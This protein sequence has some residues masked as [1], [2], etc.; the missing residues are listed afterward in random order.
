MEENKMSKGKPGRSSS[1]KATQPKRNELKYDNS[2]KS[3]RQ[4]LLDYFKNNKPFISTSEIRKEL[5]IMAPAARI[6]ELR[7]NQG[8]EITCDRI[9]ELDQNGVT[10][11]M[12]LYT[13]L[14]TTKE[15]QHG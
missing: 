3:Q 4:R 14:S 5:G 2:A 8:L 6:F 1:K 11:W 10:H 13:L 12:G 7:H 15:K 9:K